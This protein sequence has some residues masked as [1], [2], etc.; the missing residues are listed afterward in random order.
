MRCFRVFWGGLF[1]VIGF[2]SMKAQPV[3]DSVLSYWN[4]QNIYL[5]D[6]D[7]ALQLLD[8]AEARNLPNLPLF[9]IN[10]LRSM[11][12]D[13]KGEYLLTEK[14]VR[15]QLEDDSIRSVPVRKLR[16]LTM[17]VNAL[18]SQNKYEECIR[19]CKETIKLARELG[20]INSEGEMLFTM[21]NVYAGMNRL[22]ESLDM[23][24]EGIDLLKNSDDVRDLAVLS[25]AYGELMT[26]LMW[27][28]K[29]LE[30][31][32]IGKERERLVEHMSQMPGPPD[33][34]IDQQ[35][36]YLYSKMAYALQLVERS[37]EAMHYYRQFQTTDFAHQSF[38]Q[39]EI[40]PFLL[41]AGRYQEALKLNKA[42]YEIFCSEY[43][44][45]TVNYNYYVILDRFAQAYHGLK[46]YKRAN[47]YLSRAFVLNDAIYTKEKESRAQEFATVFMLNEKDLQ[48]AQ[49]HLVAQRR[50]FQMI[51]LC[52]VLVLACA[53]LGIVVYHLQI[54]RR[55]N[56][57]AA[58]QIDELMLQRDDLR[59]ACER[60]MTF[61]SI[62]SSSSSNTNPK[63]SQK[64]S[65]DPQMNSFLRMEYRV[66]EERLFL[67]PK[68]GRDD[69]LRLCNVSKNDLPRILRQYARVNNVS[70]YLNHLRVEYAV[71]LMHEKPNL[72]M[73]GIG[74][75]A[76]FNSRS[77]F[78]RAFFKEFGMTPAQYLKAHSVQEG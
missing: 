69:L 27:N 49:M 4:I 15:R 22:E 6:P 53:F 8:S 65:D 14:Y 78:Y 16:T 29:V 20:R 45:D 23:Y 12:Y 61:S 11:C 34:Y 44:K 77:T 26:T 3:P 40:I 33:G 30:A 75:E 54:I 67:Q 41:Q 74:K 7:Y 42:D 56:L 70:D 51:I 32:E 5:R 9:K 48:L 37:E 36:G 10:R 38:T 55:R 62:G 19:Y 39:G 58:K 28:K 68:F 47:A 59:R 66:M 73:D 60:A 46:D 52:I 21:G 18:S 43:E 17:L 25:T 31:I 63:D 1:A 50:N 57:V 35:Y 64:D 13:V 24:R 76:G 2:V 72:S 71:R